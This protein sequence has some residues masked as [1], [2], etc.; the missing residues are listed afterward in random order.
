MV[1]L[2]G[3]YLPE[4]GVYFVVRRLLLLLQMVGILFFSI[5]FSR[6]PGLLFPKYL[7]VPRGLVTEVPLGLEPFR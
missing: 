2:P 5:P 3:E 4:K 6:V 1:C 7:L